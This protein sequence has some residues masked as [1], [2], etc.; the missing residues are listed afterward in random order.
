MGC[1]MEFSLEEDEIVP[2]REALGRLV[3]VILDMGPALDKK[4]ALSE[5]GRAL[6]QVDEGVFKMTCEGSVVIEAAAAL[7]L[8]E[9]SLLE[10]LGSVGE[11]DPRECIPR[12]EELATERHEIARRVLKRYWDYWNPP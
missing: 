7:L 12:L 6:K 2:M 3:R 4:F 9:S 10:G 8:A 1:A 11:G 5:V